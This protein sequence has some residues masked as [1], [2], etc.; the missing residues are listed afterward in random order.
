MVL[1]QKGYHYATPWLES[2]SGEVFGFVYIQRK[3]RPFA[4]IGYEYHLAGEHL[5]QTLNYEYTYTGATNDTEALAAL[6]QALQAGPVVAGMLDM[7][8]LS[9]APG[10]IYTRGVDHAVVVLK[11]TDDTVLLH[12][13]AGFIAV[14]LPLS[15]FLEA[16]KRDVYTGKPYGLWQIGAQRSQP[17]E[18]EIWERTLTYARELCTRQEQVSDKGRFI[19]GP[20][21]IR[22]LAADIRAAADPELL[23]SFA[24]WSWQ[25]SGQRCLDGATFLRERLPEAAALRWEQ[26]LIYSQLQYASV[27]SEI[28]KAT[29]LLER[30]ADYEERFIAALGS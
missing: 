9:Y 30:L 26:C 3:Q 10:H 25:L 12:D 1:A 11:R 23:R 28:D 18:Q 17:D 15:D 29:E 5:L 27:A 20:Q 7:G 4:V 24:Y 2:V 19:C 14:P 21:G 8:Y 13:P 6:D 22:A 16:W